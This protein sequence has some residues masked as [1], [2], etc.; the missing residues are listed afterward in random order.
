LFEGAVTAHSSFGY[1]VQDEEDVD[2]INPTR[3]EI[4]NERKDFLFEVSV[5]FWDKFI[6]NDRIHMEAVSELF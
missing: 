2:N 1:P 3:C 6:S 4:N 5:I